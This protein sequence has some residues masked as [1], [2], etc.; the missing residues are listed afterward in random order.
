MNNTTK[1]LPV[2]TRRLT[3]AGLM[4]GQRL[5]RCPSIKPELVKRLVCT[6]LLAGGVCPRAR[7]RASISLIPSWIPRREDSAH[8]L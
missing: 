8:H 1:Q 3:N 2:N 5:R 6:C 4:L 7:V